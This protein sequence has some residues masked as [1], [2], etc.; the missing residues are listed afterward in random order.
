MFE[1]DKKQ[2]CVRL[3]EKTWNLV[4]EI[5]HRE[6]VSKCDVIAALIEKKRKKYEKYLTK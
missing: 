1:A 3:S 6:K 5:S 2:R 4:C